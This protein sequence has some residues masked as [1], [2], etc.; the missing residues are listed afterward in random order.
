MK[1]K[2]SQFLA[3]GLIL[4]A[5]AAAGLSF[6][7][8][9]RWG[10]VGVRGRIT[11]RVRQGPGTLLDLRNEIGFTWDEVFV[12]GPRT[13]SE[14]VAA[15]SGMPWSIRTILNL[16]SRDDICLLAFVAN[17]KYRGHII[18]PRA[19]ADFLPAVSEAPYTPQK[20]T[21]VVEAGDSGEPPQLM[22]LFPPVAPNK[23]DPR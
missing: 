16:G 23:K 9:V 19:Q 13:A 11:E 14:T 1:P 6:V 22:P 7:A 17:G 5:I 15:K 3:V 8:T 18:Y 21:F 12:M 20:A 4:A 2:R 10:N